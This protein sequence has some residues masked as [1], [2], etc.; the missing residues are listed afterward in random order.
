MASRKATR[1]KTPRRNCLWRSARAK[2]W[3]SLENAVA[4]RS[5]RSCPVPASIEPEQR[6]AGEW[7]SGSVRK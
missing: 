3:S 4:E 5:L 7:E 2:S 1:A 6:K